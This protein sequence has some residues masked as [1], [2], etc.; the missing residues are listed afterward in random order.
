MAHKR[1]VCLLVAALVLLP[2]VSNVALGQEKPTIVFGAALPL[3]GEL[4]P[5]G[6]KQ[7]HGYEFWKETVNAQG[8][9]DVG[10]TKYL[11]DIKYYDYKSDT[12]TS[13]RLVE[14]LI[15][16]D[17]V[18]FIFGPFGSG[19][20]KACASVVEK[21]GV[22]MVNP[23][24]SSENVY[25][26]GYKNV[27]GV[28]TPDAT[29]TEP[30]SDIAMSQEDPPKTIAILSRNDLFPLAIATE[31]SKSAEKRG[32]KVVYFE[33]YPVGATDLS[34]ALIAM[35]GTNA[36]WMFITGYAKDLI[37]ARRQMKEIDIN[38]KMVTMIAGAVY[39]EFLE[40][41]GAD[42]NGVTTACWWA[43]VVKYQGDDV[44]GTAEEYT[45][46]FEERYGYIPD[47]VCAASSAV[48]VVFQHGLEK[49]GVVDAAAVRDAIAGLD[50]VT[51]Y[52]PVRFGP[53][54]Q[55]VGL[56]PPVLQIQDE[57]L[58][59]IHP[60]EIAQTELIYPVPAWSK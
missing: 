21:Y 20:A 33:K 23:T 60:D 3:T 46:K 39:K 55:N 10:G 1:I 22:P 24:A 54:G 31:A 8:G 16:E 18:Q 2:L 50:V 27:F 15:T 12:A 9:I 29:L 43:N 42:A 35:K 48:G 49:A 7:M 41:L 40:G 58:L 5:E 37:L 14:K 25:E 59:V 11:V 26:Q 52:G 13:V 36:D 34:P 30:L 51:F 57:T 56:N 45:R 38:A 28:F 44:F 32:I 47:Y 6:E 17:N 19:A 53:R 4:A